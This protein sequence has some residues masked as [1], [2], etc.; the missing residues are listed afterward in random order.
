MLSSNLL[1]NEI[2]APEIWLQDKEFLALL[3]TGHSEYLA[4]LQDGYAAWTSY[5]QVLKKQIH[6]AT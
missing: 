6:I 5:L 3:M 1:L 4:Q 2:H